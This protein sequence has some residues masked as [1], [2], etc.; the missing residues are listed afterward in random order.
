LQT[1][2]VTKQ[3]QMIKEI[4]TYNRCIALVPA[5]KMGPTITISHRV[6]KEDE[7]WS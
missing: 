4:I 3:E 6:I 1:C 2:S 5:H 7:R